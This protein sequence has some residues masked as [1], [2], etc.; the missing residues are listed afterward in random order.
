[1]NYIE[2]I[3]YGIQIHPELNTIDARLKIRDRIKQNKNKWKGA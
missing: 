3:R 1:M 2:Y